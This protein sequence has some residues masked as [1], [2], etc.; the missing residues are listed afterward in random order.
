LEGVG[1]S[2]VADFELGRRAVSAEKVQDIRLAQETAGIMFIDG[3]GV[4][5]RKD[6]R[7]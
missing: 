1:L 7:K 2:T 4:M 5:L 6:R 3:D